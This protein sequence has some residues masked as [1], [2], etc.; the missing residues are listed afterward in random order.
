MERAYLRRDPAYEGIFVIAVRTTGVF[1]RPTCRV[2]SP[3]PKNVEF[4]PS[5]KEALFAGY[6]P[7]K[8]CRPLTQDEEPAWATDLL[9]DVE[10]APSDRIRESD[11]RARGIDPATA[12]RYFQRH[13]G[14]TF[15]AYARARRLSAAFTSIRNGSTIDETVFDSGYDSHSGFRQA[16]ARTFG[17]APG[18]AQR[19]ATGTNWLRLAWLRSP[20]GP[21]IAGANDAGICFLEFSDRRMLEAQLGTLRSRFQ[22]TVAPGEHRHIDRLR[23]EL[24]EY[25]AG[26]RTKFAVPLVAPGTPFQERVWAAL[27]RIPFGQTTSYQELAIQIGA[28]SAVRAVGH[29]NGLNRIAILIPCHRVIAKDGGLGGYGGGLRRKEFLLR[30]EGAVTVRTKTAAEATPAR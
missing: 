24:D 4:F 25:F 30:L 16:F 1:C 11:L 14:M 18:A 8:R 15:Q 19:G 22:T 3:L 27:Q 9:A 7:C 6:R 21:L 23:I 26:R 5:P 12:R 20:L 10:H 2:R 29:A 17:C 13:F 28:G